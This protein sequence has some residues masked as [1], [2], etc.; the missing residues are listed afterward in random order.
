MEA[1]ERLYPILSNPLYT[2]LFFLALGIIPRI[3]A[4]YI[5]PVDWNPDSYHHWQISFL[6]LKL[7]IRE[8]RLWDLNGCEF[9]W[10]VIP[11]LVQVFLQWIVGT[12]SIAPYRALNIILGGAN[13]YLVYL[14]GRDNVYWRVGLFASLFFALYPIGIV[15]DIVAMQETLALTFALLSLY[16]FNSRPG[17]AGLFLALAAQSR[18]EFWLVSIIFVICTVSVERASQKAWAFALGW[19]MV[20]VIFC[21]LYRFWTSNPFYPLY[22]SLFSVFGGWTERGRGLPL[23]RLML[24]W[25][26]F[27]MQ[28]WPFSAPGQI[29]LGS[30]LTLT[31][32]VVQMLRRPKKGYHLA[33]FFLVTTVVFGPIFL[34]YYPDHEKHLL[35]MLRMSFPMAASGAVLLFSLVYRTRIMRLNGVLRNVDL[36]LLL[37]A[38]LVVPGMGVIPS[39]VRFQEETNRAF[40]AADD[41][42][43][44]YKG[45]T[46]VCDHPTMNY[47]LVTRWGVGATELLGNHY[48]PHYYGIS[49]PLRYAEWLAKHNVTL[50]LYSGSRAYPVWAVVSKDVP[51]LLVYRDESH[52]TRIYEVNRTRIGELLTG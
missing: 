2:F 31:G 46:I 12:P 25:L 27:R 8:G 41:A 26:S 42:Y 52:G 49:N 40:S 24:Q 43:S 20:T 17:R 39:Y 16:Y 5:I 11:H 18:T 10:G 44:H 38:L 15:F 32:S 50:W 23:H 13:T 6:T 29:L 1:E 35:Y 19:L 4:L 28:S 45:G 30:A 36:G 14:I 34:P 3:A 48:S 9:Y 22:W 37:T 33:L 21:L 7:G 51:G 47:R